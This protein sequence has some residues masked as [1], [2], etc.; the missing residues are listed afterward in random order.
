L[1]QIIYLK[2][3]LTCGY[4]FFCGI[5]K[6]T[7]FNGEFF[8]PDL[9][10]NIH[11]LKN[12]YLKLFCLFFS[13]FVL[14]NCNKIIAQC[15]VP[16]TSGSVTISIANNVINTY[17][18][19]I[20]SP[21]A[22]STSLNVGS[23][24]PRGNTTAIST[25]DLVL[26]VQVQGADID[27]T[28]TDSYGDNTAGAPASGYIGTNLSAGYYEYNTIAGISGSTI[29]FSYSLA[30]N[31]YNRDFTSTNSIQRYEVIRVPR[32]Y[33]LRIKHGA[34]LT[35]PEWN[36][37]TGGIVV[38]D[39][40]NQFTLQGTIDVSYKGFR[41]GGGK[42]LTGATAGNSNGAGTLTNTDYRWESPITNS[43]NLTGGAKGEGIAGTPAYYLEYGSSFTTTG[44]VE[45]YINGS[46]GRGAPANAGGG[47]TD[48]S[49]VGASTENQYNT[50]GGGGANG[51]NGGNG[52]SGWHG[53]SGD[54][55]TY[56]Y[57]GYGG[58]A[59]SQRSL[60]RFCMGG[61]GGAGTANNS[62]ASNEYSCSGGWG[63][64]IVIVRA[65]L[66][67]GN[68][69]VFANG[70]NAP[71]VTDIYVPAQTDA[72]GGGGA[73][74]SIVMVTTLPG[75]TGLNTIT[76]SATGGSGGDMTNY[77]DYGPGGG[78]GGGVIISNGTFL[79]ADVS[80]GLNGLTLTGS[81]SGS[82]DNAYGA[83]PG[84]DGVIIT[85]TS[86]PTLV[87][88]NNPG[89]PCGLLPVTLTD[90][91]ARWNN[92]TVDLKW[93]ITNEI[94][95]K[96]FELE[97][98]ADGISFTKLASLNYHQGTSAYDYT[99]LNPL[100]KNFYGLKMIDADGNYFY[101]KILRVQKN[102]SGNKMVL[103]YPNPAY[104]DL[105]LQL[106]TGINEKVIINIVDNAGKTVINKTVTLPS[107][108]NYI[109]ID[110]I[111][112]LPS[113][114]YLVKVKSSSVNAVEKLVVGKK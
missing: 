90:F 36:G 82:F 91:S 26:I 48:G 99:H 103:M 83:T 16:P 39:V 28:N 95:L 4:I 101:S 86:A 94:N 44:S 109:S 33:D 68:G 40:A 85:L 62:I 113:A 20:G 9:F 105:T 21:A 51:G 11:M 76:A 98:S 47:G 35:C 69:S 14:I 67:S 22:G 93:K 15:G 75:P 97:Y 111:D 6:S 64:G 81:P 61:G 41:G 73:G 57:G 37:N 24:D 46:M 12:F 92:N 49:P 13:F 84:S 107:G 10:K 63:G 100:V 50:G 77:Y 71:G 34:S 29:T 52:G 45:G 78:G 87:N 55:N 88:L 25:G 1:L 104:N 19:G 108:Q 96:S 114:T 2:L 23:I 5:P 31:Y 3:R 89:S 58:S 106:T 59:F 30:N 7:I 79:S 17:Y 70:S 38:V 110:G 43:A 42:N 102:I 60:Q 18:P 80:G 53:G 8:Y 27:A 65:K 74:G 66:Y 112:K 54:V 56:P 72:A 32:Y